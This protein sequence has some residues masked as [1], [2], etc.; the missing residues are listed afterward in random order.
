VG[1]LIA[2]KA[3]TAPSKQAQAFTVWYLDLRLCQEYFACAQSSEDPDE[4][5]TA[6]TIQ[7]PNTAHAE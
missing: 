4:G 5:R 3:F 6:P 7:T 1:H 2:L